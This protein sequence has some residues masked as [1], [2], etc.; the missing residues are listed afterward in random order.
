MKTLKRYAES[1]LFFVICIFFTAIIIENSRGFA[2]SIIARLDV[3]FAFCHN[4]LF[5]KHWGNSLPFINECINI[6]T[7]EHPFLSCYVCVK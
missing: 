2:I 4:G 3:M 7:I 5:S 1:I 6:E